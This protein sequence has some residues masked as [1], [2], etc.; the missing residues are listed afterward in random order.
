LW[1][2]EGSTKNDPRSRKRKN[3][4]Q[5]HSKIVVSLSI[6]CVYLYGFC[7]CY[8]RFELFKIY[9]KYILL[10]PRSRCIL[11]CDFHFNDAFKFNRFSSSVQ[12]HYNTENWGLHFLKHQENYSILGFK[13]YQLKLFLFK[14][15]RNTSVLSNFT[16][17]W[18]FLTPCMTARNLACLLSDHSMFRNFF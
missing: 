10:D 13:H 8:K 18:V 5:S 6:N 16:A 15:N 4:R 9:A 7:V 12:V 14:H 2:L 11:Y 3:D 17:F 1:S